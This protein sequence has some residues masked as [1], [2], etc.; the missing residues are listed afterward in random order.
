M[1][2]LHVTLN[3]ENLL[4]AS[5]DECCSLNWDI[6]CSRREK[7]FACF[8]VSGSI[9]RGD[10]KYDTVYWVEG[11]VLDFDDQLKL[12]LIPGDGITP[13]ARRHTHEELEA[14]RLEVIRAEEAGEYDDARAARREPLRSSCGIALRTPDGISREVRASGSIMTVLCGG[15][16]SDLRSS[17][18]RLRLW[19]MPTE[20]TASGFW[21]PIE[22][23]VNITMLA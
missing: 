8:S 7:G 12:Q 6:A 11:L 14:L 15:S 1:T 23:G 5:I 3:G 16:W 21:Q 2:A 4:H 10:G 18:W 22:G 17:E 13:V 9:E 20:P 19:S